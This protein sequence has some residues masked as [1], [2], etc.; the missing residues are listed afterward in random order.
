MHNL[1]SSAQNGTCQLFAQFFG[2]LPPLIIDQTDIRMD[3]GNLAE[4][5]NAAGDKQSIAL[6][7]ALCPSDNNL[8]SDIG[9][10]CSTF[11]GVVNETMLTVIPFVPSPPF[12][13]NEGL[14]NKSNI[15][16]CTPARISP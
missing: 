14:G 4:D 11:N 16:P 1:D 9:V 10:A 5:G 3:H 7:G 2:N 6:Q 13:N 8:V 15:S 12:G